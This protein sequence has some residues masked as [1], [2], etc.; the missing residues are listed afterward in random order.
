MSAPTRLNLAHESQV[1]EGNLQTR[2]RIEIVKPAARTDVSVIRLSD[3]PPGRLSTQQELGSLRQRA[4]ESNTS[5]P[6]LEDRRQ[7]RS[8]RKLSLDV[9]RRVVRRLPE[10]GVTLRGRFLV[11]H[12]RLVRHHPHPSQA[13][14]PGDDYPPLVEGLKEAP[15]RVATELRELAKDQDAVMGECSRMSLEGAGA[16]SRHRITHCGDS[17]L[18]TPRPVTVPTHLRVGPVP[19]TEDG[20]HGHEGSAVLGGE[21]YGGQEVPPANHGKS[22][23]HGSS[24]SRQPV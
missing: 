5:A 8:V 15:H 21:R 17:S 16:Q 1:L 10:D 14:H 6:K 3:P 11:G 22:S 18:G 19:F 9:V 12:H 7:S 13:H 24:S 20:H 2:L 23:P 4:L